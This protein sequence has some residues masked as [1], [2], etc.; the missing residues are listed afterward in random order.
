MYF[1]H[2]RANRRLTTMHDR[3]KHLIALVRLAGDTVRPGSA[4]LVARKAA[5]PG[6]RAGARG[7][8]PAS[9]VRTEALTGPAA[10]VLTRL[11][12]RMLSATARQQLAGYIKNVALRLSPTTSTTA[13]AT[14]AVHAFKPGMVANAVGSPRAYSRLY[15][16]W[17]TDSLFRSEYVNAKQAPAYFDKLRA[18]VDRKYG[19][20]LAAL[21]KLSRLK[22]GSAIAKWGGRGL[23]VLGPAAHAWDVVQGYRKPD[24]FTD[25]LDAAAG[26][27]AVKGTLNVLGSAP[28]APS[29]GVR[30]AVD[31]HRALDNV[32]ASQGPQARK[33]AKAQARQAFWDNL[34]GPGS[35]PLRSVRKPTSLGPTTKAQLEAHA[36]K[37]QEAKAR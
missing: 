13:G 26:Q 6:P 18:A 2:P 9:L 12:D 32:E 27:G 7:G 14:R 37:V 20:P 4:V 3:L 33:W 19:R 11:G 8:S 22:H 25:V 35:I 23:R 31:T 24:T 28:R 5:P 15:K 30:Y 10:D 16:P 17:V 34:F 1:G 29:A 36:R 21:S